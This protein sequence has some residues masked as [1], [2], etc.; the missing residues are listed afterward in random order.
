MIK[1]ITVLL[2]LLFISGCLDDNSHS[3]ETVMFECIEDSNGQ[4]GE[5]LKEGIKTSYLSIDIIDIRYIKVENSNAHFILLVAFLNGLLREE[6]SERFG[7]AHWLIDFKD[8]DTQ[9]IYSIPGNASSYF[10]FDVL[11]TDAEIWLYEE[12]YWSAVNS[13]KER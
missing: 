5:A 2:P 7:Y 11:D 3:N 8:S 10:N 9:K 1:I 12:E 6:E 4:L 13:C